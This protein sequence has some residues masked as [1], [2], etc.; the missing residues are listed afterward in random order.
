MLCDHVC[1]LRRGRVVVQGAMS[2]LLSEGERRREITLGAL[3]APSR[4]R[5]RR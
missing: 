4:R 2:E 5:L 3:L 1:I